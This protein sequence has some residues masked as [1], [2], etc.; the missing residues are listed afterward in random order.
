MRVLIISHGHPSFSIGGAEVASHTL[1][2]ALNDVPGHE[3][4]YLS[5]APG[6]VRRH[7]ATPL[8][9]LGH[10][11]RE[12]FVCTGE[13]DEF[14]LSN[15]GIGDL[16]RAVA[17]YLR[18]LD[19]DVVH[20]HHVI[21]LGIEMLAL[22]KRV[23]PR[24][25][26]VV[27]FHEYLSICLNHGQMVRTQRREL[28]RQASPAN[29]NTCFPHIGAA[30]FYGRQAHLRSHLA[31]A[32]AYIS[33]SRFLAERYVEWGLPAA[34]FRV[35]ENGV[36]GDRACSRSLE[37]GRRRNRFGFFGQI[38]EF[39]GLAIVLDAVTRLP[40]EIWGRCYP[41]RIRRK[42][43]VS[44]RG[45]PQP[46]RGAHVSGGTTSE[47]LRKLSAGRIGWIDVGHRLGDRPID[48]VGE[49]SSR[50]PGGVLPPPSTHRQW[51]RW[52]G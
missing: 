51:R 21:G 25:R 17:Q 47:V 2:R 20:F 29:C 16:D 41:E 24:A 12:L 27:T 49:F 45:V 4:F 13:W 6:S 1:F 42:P 37:K 18:H 9:S 36:G 30:Q 31:L 26:I 7:A 15:A 5:R 39:K 46:L 35:I 14:W 40:D 44:T 43:R 32:D 10:S 38:T 8:M 33:P 22:I 50:H 34:R 48:M 28:C 19:P 23:L 11:E 52:D 3:A